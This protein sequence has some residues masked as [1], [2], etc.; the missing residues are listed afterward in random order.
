MSITKYLRNLMLVIASLNIGMVS[1]NN[2]NQKD[3]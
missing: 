1:A 2:I 3:T